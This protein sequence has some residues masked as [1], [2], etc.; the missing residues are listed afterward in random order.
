MRL[1]P[2]VLPLLDG[3]TMPGCIRDSAPDAWGRRVIINK[4]LGSKGKD[5]DTDALGELTYLLESGSDRMAHWIFSA[6]PVNTFRAR[7]TMFHWKN[8]CNPQRG[9]NKAYRSP[10]SGIRRSF[11]AA[12]SAAHVPKR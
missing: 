3:L 2:G 11:M 6:P 1:K 10:L 8:C 4:K 5:S 9:L 7:Q 12:L